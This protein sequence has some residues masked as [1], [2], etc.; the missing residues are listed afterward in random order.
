MRKVSDLNLEKHRTQEQVELIKENTVHHR[1]VW[2]IFYFILFFFHCQK[3]NRKQAKIKSKGGQNPTP[4]YFTNAPHT[5]IPVYFLLLCQ[6]PLYFN[7]GE[8][9]YAKNH[10]YFVLDYSNTI[11]QL[12]SA[13][14]RC[15]PHIKAPSSSKQKFMS[16]IFSRMQMIEQMPTH[17]YESNFCFFFNENSYFHFDFEANSNLKKKMKIV[18]NPLFKYFGGDQERATH[19][20]K[21]DL[22]VLFFFLFFWY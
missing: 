21:V 1:Q 12:F 13:N 14:N 22:H 10:S 9:S 3:T 5:S 6:N 19:N 15:C 7:S 8:Y 18:N 2:E 20:L 11:T 16:I 4:K 17:R